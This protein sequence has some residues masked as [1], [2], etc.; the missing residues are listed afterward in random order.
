MARHGGRVQLKE[1]TSTLLSTIA[2]TGDGTAIGGSV[3]FAIPGTI[4]RCRSYVQATMDATKQV[5][6]LI[7]LT[8]GLGIF[9]TDAFTLGASAMPEPAADSAY[10][11]LWWG[12]MHLEAQ[13]AAGEDSWG[14]SNQRLEVDTKAMRRFKPTQTLGW[15]VESH[16]S[17]GAP[18]TS[19]TFGTTRI[20]IGT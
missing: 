7:T 19:V 20:L 2:L 8:F 4:L 14:S 12:Q 5:G 18:V 13:V 6:D 15:V 16:A 10:P 9:S 1:W 3:G 17:A 11:W